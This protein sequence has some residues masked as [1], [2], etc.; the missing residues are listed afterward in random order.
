M[1][2]K[3]LEMALQKVRGFE[4]PDPALEQYMTPAT[5]A[6]EILFD[7]YRAGD[8]EGM[9]VVDLGCGTGMFSIG[10][11]LLGAGMSIGFDTSEKALEVARSNAE[12]LEVDVEFVLSDIR[13]V[14]EGADTIFMNPPFGCQNK[15]ADRPFLDRAM[16]LSEC[17][18][19]IHM[20]ETL[21][22]V[23]GYCEKR[24][25]QVASYKIY[26]Y[27]IPHVFAFHTKTKKTID[28]AVVNIR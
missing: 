11:A 27:E 22:F 12:A 23:K 2:R 21:N 25:R 20:A 9:K 3:D 17:V 1:K 13:D 4:D 16:E 14:E 28:V 5:M 26:K 19:S 6:S 8:V 7:A 10:A 15:N 18:Y 24:G